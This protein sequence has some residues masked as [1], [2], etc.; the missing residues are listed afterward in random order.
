[1]SDASTTAT[2]RL[3][4][5]PRVG[6][7]AQIGQTWRQSQA[8]YL[9]LAPYLI[10]FVVILAYPLVFSIYLSFFDA[11]LNQA[12]TFVGAQNFVHLFTDGEFLTALRNTS[13]YAVFVV[14]GET[15]L[16]LFMAIAMNERL[17]FRTVLRTAYFLPVV[18]SWTVVS[19][20]W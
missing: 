18:T 9:L 16:P 5:A 13:Y 10:L 3:G 1:M 17:P 7:A 11:T 2:P 14:I 8:A 19:L 4:A 6:R 20:I 15:I 12:P